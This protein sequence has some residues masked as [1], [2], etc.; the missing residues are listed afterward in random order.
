MTHNFPISNWEQVLPDA[1]H[2]I[3]STLCTVT[4][5]TPHERFFNFQRKSSVG[6]SMPSWLRPGKV[7]LRRFV[8]KSKH[9]P[10]V[11]E[12]ELT[13][14]NPTYAHI[15]YP[16]GRES[17]VSIHDLAPFPQN[18]SY[19]TDTDCSRPSI[20]N[21]V[22]NSEDSVNQLVSN[23]Q[24]QPILIDSDGPG[25]SSTSQIPTEHSSPYQ[26]PRRSNRQNRGIPPHRLGLDE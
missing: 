13:D 25:S 4:N 5:N 14:I 11:D 10:L 22:L 17:T 3:R 15:R 21:D 9:D 26:E 19:D 23:N 16:D 2:S 18:V 6:K 7:M 8:R 24:Q 20:C 12:V 1:L